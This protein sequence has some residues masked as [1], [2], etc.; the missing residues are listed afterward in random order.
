MSE[1][2]IQKA[3]DTISDFYFGE[4]EDSGEAMFQDFAKKHHEK[5]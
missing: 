5:L 3:M 4:S 1:D 2:K